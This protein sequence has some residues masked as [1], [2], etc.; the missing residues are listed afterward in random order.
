[1]IRSA[2]GDVRIEEEGT[3]P[4]LGGG[5]DLPRATWTSHL[6]P[7]DTLILM[8][9]GVVEAVNRDIDRAFDEI[10]KKLTQTGSSSEEM[11]DQLFGMN[12]DDHADDAAALLVRWSPPEPPAQ[13]T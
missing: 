5:V 12:P 6:L 1:M 3:G 2:A 13:V 10:S 11:L 4:P 7:G 9:D 8:T